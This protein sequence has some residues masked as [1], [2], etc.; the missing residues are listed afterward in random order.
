MISCHR[1]HNHV[2]CICTCSSVSLANFS[3][4]QP[5]T[6]LMVTLASRVCSLCSLTDKSTLCRERAQGL[7]LT[8]LLTHHTPNGK[9]YFCSS[10]CIC[11][12]ECLCP[13]ECLCPSECLHPCKCLFPS[14][15]TI[16]ENAP[17][18]VA[19]IVGRLSYQ[20]MLPMRR[21]IHTVQ[22]VNGT[23]S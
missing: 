17:S 3:D 1:W 4:S 10:E 18:D 7:C 14:E 12:S 23:R 21:G 13:T 16:M 9:Y 20:S 5:Q 8:S 11:P 2:Q 6:Q 15:S 22:A 19:F